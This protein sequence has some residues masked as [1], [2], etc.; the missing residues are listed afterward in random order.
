MLNHYCDNL[1]TLTEFAHIIGLNPF[2]LHQLSSV[3]P[4]DTNPIFSDDNECDEVFY[5]YLWQNQ[6]LARDDIQRAIH[7]AE[8]MFYE[9]TGYYPAPREI[10]EEFIL[11]DYLRGSGYSSKQYYSHNCA[12]RVALG[13]KYIQSLGTYTYTRV[14]DEVNLLPIDI[15]P[16][17]E[18]NLVIDVGDLPSG[19]LPSEIVL[20]YHPDVQNNCQNDE[21][22]EW[23]VKPITATL[24]N[25]D[26]QIN[27]CGKS[28]LIVKADEVT[29]PN[30]SALE[31][32]DLDFYE[33]RFTIYTKTL[34][35][36]NT[37]SYQCDNGC[38]TVS[39]ESFCA[40]TINKKLSL[41]ET[42]IATLDEETDAFDCCGCGTCSCCTNKTLTINY[43]AGCPRQSNGRMN[44]RC[45]QIISWLAASLLPCE[46]CS[47]KCSPLHFYRQPNIGMVNN[48]EAVFMTSNMQN[49]YRWGFRR[50][51]IMA[52]DAIRNLRIIDGGYAF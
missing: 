21:C 46:N 39:Q 2:Q 35:T 36:T 4:S 51:A 5:E 13:G 26:T 48:E 11:R 7:Q 3:D 38:C 18:F 43:I 6:E 31:L 14:I 52:W 16:L 44:F 45:A 42:R 10:T 20:V 32:T 12:H 30:P 15:N 27:I 49:T 17:S 22:L 1:L 19:T 37:G 41:I 29:I 24:I 50:G 34:N 25:D 23:E 9:E 8:H 33:T 40:N 28:F 47:C